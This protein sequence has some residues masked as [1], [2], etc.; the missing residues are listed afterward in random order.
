MNPIRLLP[1]VALFSGLLAQNVATFPSDHATIPVGY[2]SQSTFPYSYGVSRVMAVYEAWDLT[3]PN[4]HQITRIGFRAHGTTV[5]LG[6]SL[7][8]EVRMGTTLQTAASLVTNFDNNYLAPPTTVFGPALFTLPDLN[9]G[10]NPIQEVWLNLTTP[11]NYDATKNLIVEWRI[12]ANSN[13][14]ASFSYPL[15]RVQFDS[16]ISSGLPGCMHSGNQAPRLLSRPTK[17]GGT[18]YN[19]LSNAPANQMAVLFLS[20]GAPLQPQYPLST[21]IP[22]IAPSCVGQLSVQNLFTVA[23]TANASGSHTFSVPIPN[24][25]GFN[26]LLFSSQTVCFDF[27]SP[28]GVVV[29][30]GD[31]IRIGIDPA[32]TVLW[33]QGSATAATGSAYRNYGMLTMFGYN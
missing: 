14:G 33:N 10:V 3:V 17:V 29:S 6:K 28:G 26:D 15:D 18:W 8:L 19:D 13:A 16:P 20:L 11:Y 24:Q 23:T 4:G 2:S 25:R 12:T 27:F 5:A 1:A 21:F 22:G 9:T 7:Q 32:M 31:Q 30:N